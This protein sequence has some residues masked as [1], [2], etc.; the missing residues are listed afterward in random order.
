MELIIILNRS[1]SHCDSSLRELAAQF[2]NGPRASHH[3][4]DHR[5]RLDASTTRNHSLPASLAALAE[6]FCILQISALASVAFKIN[7]AALFP[8]LLDVGMQFSFGAEKF[9]NLVDQP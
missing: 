8:W 7:T 9:V 3:F 4:A 2:C 6:A 1:W 5:A